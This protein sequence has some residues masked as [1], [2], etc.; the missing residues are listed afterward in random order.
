[1]AHQ[2]LRKAAKDYPDHGIAKGDQYY[3]A[4]I[5]TGPRSSRTIRSKSPI[6]RSQLTTSEFLSTLY[7]IEDVDIPSCSCP[8]DIESVIDSLRELGEEQREKY[9]NMPEGL[10]QGDTG[11]LLEQRADGCEAACG[12][13]EDIQTRWE[14]ELESAGDDEV[15]IERINEEFGEELQGV[16][17]DC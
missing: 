16:T 13:L 6:P 9:D 1:M 3:F 2:K 4:Q 5:K 8:A 7:G 11:Q 10:Q 12:E 14:S 15:E 17:I